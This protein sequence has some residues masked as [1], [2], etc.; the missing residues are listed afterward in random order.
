MVRP[1]ENRSSVRSDGAQLA[2]WYRTLPTCTRFLLGSTCTLSLACAFGL[3]Y[4]G[5]LAL[6]WPAVMGRFQVWRLVTSFLFVLP[7]INGLIHIIMLFRHS[8][9]LETEEFARRTADYAWFLLFCGFLIA[10]VSW[11]TATGML[12]GGLLLALVTLWSLHRA[13]QTVSFLLGIRFPARYLPYA[14]I[15]LDFVLDGG[16]MPLASLYGWGAAQA[17]YY[18]SVDLP[19]QG[20][21]NYIPT[22][23]LVYRLLGQARRTDPRTVSVG[24]A[25]SGQPIHQQPGGGHNWGSGRR[26]A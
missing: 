16:V 2:H 9:A 23:Q 6:Y 22:P 7:G 26:L 21:L 10:G 20:G 4:P 3:V 25:T 13:E 11:I 1:A 17:Y 19:A 8:H 18:L 12:S 15:G 14:M 24:Y 5:R